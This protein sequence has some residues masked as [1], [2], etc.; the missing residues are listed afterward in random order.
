MPVEA[1][2]LFSSPL[3]IF[4]PTTQYPCYPTVAGG[5]SN[6]SFRTVLHLTAPP[7]VPTADHRNKYP[8]KPPITINCY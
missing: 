3:S 5:K 4:K 1:A 6:S 2:T 8:N 7:P